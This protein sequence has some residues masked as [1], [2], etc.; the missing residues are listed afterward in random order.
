MRLGVLIAVVLIALGGFVLSGKATWRSK[1]A[2]VDIGILQASVTEKQVV[3][4]WIGAVA[5]GAGVLVLVT[6]LKRSK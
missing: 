3:P 4:K 5:I 6:T 1:K 2:N